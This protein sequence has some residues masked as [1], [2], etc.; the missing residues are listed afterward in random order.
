MSLAARVKNHFRDLR[1]NAFPRRF[2]R[3]RIRNKYGNGQVFPVWQSDNP[4]VIRRGGYALLCSRGS[5]LVRD[6]RA[7]RQQAFQT[8]RAWRRFNQVL[9]QQNLTRFRE[10][11]LLMQCTE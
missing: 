4:N 9:Q 3:R 10:P 5:R 2:V 1:D 7:G 8:F 6:D 11:A